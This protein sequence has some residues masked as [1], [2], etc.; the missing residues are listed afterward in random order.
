AFITF[1]TFILLLITPTSSSPD[2]PLPPIL[3]RWA[4]FLGVSSA[5][6]AAIQYAPQLVHTYKAKIVGALSIPMMCIQSPGAVLMVLSIA[7]RPGTNW[8]SW[9]TFAVS[10]IMQG[11]LLIMC[12]VFYFRQRRLGLDEFGNPLPESVSQESFVGEPVDESEVPGLVTDVEEDPRKVG[13]ALARALE[14]ATGSDIRASVEE[15]A[16]EET[17]L[18]GKVKQENRNGWSGWFGRE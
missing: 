9:V 7:L 11:S 1:T 16:S 6:L 13:V 14:S 18:L 8:T 15:D 12:V 17:P 5:I 3:A 4:T 2:V 10:G